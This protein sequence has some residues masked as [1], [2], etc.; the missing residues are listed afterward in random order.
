M[1]FYVT[2]RYCGATTKYQY[3]CDCNEK[4]A[5]RISA[6]LVGM[7]VVDSVLLIDQC[8]SYL[9]QKYESDGGKQVCVQI[10]INDC[11][12]EEGSHSLINEIDARTFQRYKDRAQN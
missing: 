10:T 5:K 2:C 7:R 6:S 12:D 8:G 4:N 9:I 11:G 1:G 3:E